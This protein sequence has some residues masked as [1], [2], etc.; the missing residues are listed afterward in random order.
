MPWYFLDFYFNIFGFFLLFFLLLFF[1]S[2]SSCPIKYIAH[3]FAC[4]QKSS[5][6]AKYIHACTGHHCVQIVN[7]R[8]RWLSGRLNTPGNGSSIPDGRN[9]A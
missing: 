6:R 3:L 4:K 8:P 9:D 5:T 1:F 7:S 2:S